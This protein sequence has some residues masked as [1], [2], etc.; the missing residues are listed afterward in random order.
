MIVDTDVLIAA[1]A[2]VIVVCGVEAYFYWRVS[3]ELTKMNANF[4]TV[5]DALSALQSD[6]ANESTVIDGAIVLINGIPALIQNAVQQ[7][8]AAGASPSQLQAFHD[9]G[10]TITAKANAL[11]SAVASAPSGNVAP[12]AGVTSPAPVSSAS[13]GASTSGGSAGGTDSTI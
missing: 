2:L 11:A 10:D 4:Q 8:L 3:K 5:A 6:V 7:A 12:G 13:T 9:L 1:F